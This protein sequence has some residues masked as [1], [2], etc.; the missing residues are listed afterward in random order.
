MSVIL[1]FLQNFT[2]SLKMVEDASQSILAKIG[3]F[4]A[5]VFKLQGFG[6]WQAAVALL[7]GLVAKE[8][9]VPS[10]SMFYGFSVTASG[11]AVAAA[12]TGFTPLSAFSFLVFILLYVPCVAAVSTIRREMNSAKWT[13]I[14]IG[15]QL[16]W[17]YVISALVYQIGRLLG[18]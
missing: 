17:A 4:I 2:F 7:T 11:A 10:L 12:L 15:W 16:G 5:P 3:T 13:L 6:F 1:W 18:L 8:S 14:S 9:V